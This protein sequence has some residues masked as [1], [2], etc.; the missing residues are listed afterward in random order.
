MVR[1]L[2]SNVGMVPHRCLRLFSF[3]T[4]QETQLSPPMANNV[5][6]PTRLALRAVFCVVSAANEAG[7]RLLTDVA[8]SRHDQ[9]VI[10][11]RTT[12]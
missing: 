4:P 2:V 5:L 7:H 3:K 6:G 12:S 11:Y 10:D 9:R 8:T 1:L